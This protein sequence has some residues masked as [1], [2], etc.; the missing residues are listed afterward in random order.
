MIIHIY[1]FLNK[2][3]LAQIKGDEFLGVNVNQTIDD[4]SSATLLVNSNSKFNDVPTQGFEN[5]YIEDDYGN[6]IFGGI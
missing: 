2:N 4:F 6:I 1:D 3:K 5:V